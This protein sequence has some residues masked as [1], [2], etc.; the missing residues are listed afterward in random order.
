[1]C[2]VNSGLRLAL[3]AMVA[4]GCSQ[5]PA[6][7]EPGRYAV[8]AQVVD[9][10]TG[11]PAPPQPPTQA[12]SELPEPRATE[13]VL[14]KLEPLPATP[15]EP[16]EPMAPQ[17]SP[18]EEALL[19]VARERPFVPVESR[20]NG[21]PAV[22]SFVGG[23]DRCRTVAITYPARRVA[24]LWRACADGRFALDREA[25]AIPD[26][27]DDPG[28]QAAR[29]ATTHWAYVNG[30]ADAAYGEVMIRAQSS[31]QPDRNGCMTIRNA[32]TWNGVAIGMMDETVCTPPE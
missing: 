18:E 27:P 11:R 25:E 32:V 5:Q 13:P 20:V 31:G 28:L 14:R 6:P 9:S 2:R 23:D 8:S 22:M 29:Q 19:G 10:R 1:M 16:D 17:R 24:E 21:Q 15:H 26:L 12:A 30:R 7:I 4:T 3:C